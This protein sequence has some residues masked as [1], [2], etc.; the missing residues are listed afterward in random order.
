MIT[1]SVYPGSC[2]LHKLRPLS[3]QRRIPS[4]IITKQLSQENQNN[5]AKS[6]F[7]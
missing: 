4:I 2:I 5:L 3:L 7:L 1:S 6:L